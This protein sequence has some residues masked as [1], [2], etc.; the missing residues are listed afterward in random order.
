MEA[1]PSATTL[2]SQQST[3]RLSAF[4]ADFG[5]D[6]DV[7]DGVE[8]GMGAEEGEVEDC[9]TPTANPLLAKGVSHSVKE[10]TPRSNDSNDL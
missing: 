4:G 9:D 10:G 5:A 7:L 2:Y 1:T 3:V 6:F 8:E